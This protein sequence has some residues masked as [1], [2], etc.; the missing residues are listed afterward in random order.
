MALPPPRVRTLSGWLRWALGLTAACAFFAVGAVAWLVHS[1]LGQLEVRR[2][3]LKSAL[4]EARAASTEVVKSAQL[5]RTQGIAEEVDLLLAPLPAADLEAGRIG[6]APGLVERLKR[7]R[8]GRAGGVVLV[9][10]ARRIVFDA[11]DDLVGKP[12]AD[13]FP[14]LGPLLAQARWSNGTTLPGALLRDNRLAET[15]V[16]GNEFW[17]ATP[18]GGGRLTLTTHAE[19]DG[20]NAAALAKAQATLDG[21]FADSA[22][23]DERLVNRIMSSLALMLLLGV[24]VIS[25]VAREFRKRVLFP[26]RHL[27]AV[28]EKI[29]SGDLQRR[30][31]VES[32]DELETLGHSINAM[33]D[34]LAQLIAGE[35]KKQRLEHNILRLLQQVSRASQG[36]LTA[37]GEVTPDELGSVV[38]GFNHMLDSIG[39]LAAE[40]RRAGVDVSRAADAILQAA[41]RT[42]E[43]AARQAVALDA[44]SRKIQALGQRSLEITRIVEL[45]EEIAAQTNLLALNAALEASKA[46]TP[47]YREDAHKGFGLIADEVRKLAE[48]SGASTKEIAAFMESIQEATDDA[49]RAVEEIRDVTRSTAD[50]TRETTQAAEAVVASARTLEQSIARFKMPSARPT[51]DTQARALAELKRRRDELLATLKRLEGELKALES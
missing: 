29:R 30:T 42:A 22:V 19:L 20:R 31:K 6:S 7:A 44:V 17:V 49:G 27:T 10:S 51:D 16:Y 50:S 5:D 32:G 38:D 26:V 4:D 28:A 37:R 9:S 45:V 40:V 12:A 8:V 15:L 18:V 34:R 21:V 23:T 2:H 14:A 11:D 48:R 41:G 43:G 1:E 47:A 3:H 39:K 36:D 35:E 33:L 13:T 46:P 24:I 25:L